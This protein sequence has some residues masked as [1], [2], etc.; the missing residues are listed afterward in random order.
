MTVVHHSFWRETGG[1]H[2][3]YS[4]FQE[5]MTMK[6]TLILVLVLVLASILLT[7]T[8]SADKAH[9]IY[10][11]YGTLNCKVCHNGQADVTAGCTLIPHSEGELQ[12]CPKDTSCGLWYEYMKSCVW[13][14]HTDGSGT[15]HSHNTAHNKHYEWHIFGQHDMVICPFR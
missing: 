1:R 8:A 7:A 14:T 4:S 6:K 15:C 13:G 10:K 11:Q 9:G 5:V 2:T 3:D 12:A